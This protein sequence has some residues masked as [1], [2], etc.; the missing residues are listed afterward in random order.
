MGEEEG[1]HIR[2]TVEGKLDNLN[3]ENLSFRISCLGAPC[4]N[5]GGD[6]VKGGGRFAEWKVEACEWGVSV[7]VPIE[8]TRERRSNNQLGRLL[9]VERIVRGEEGWGFGG[10][11]R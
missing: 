6:G 10:E 2:E 7:R 9:G 1:L 3:G 5:R 4:R 11:A 8:V